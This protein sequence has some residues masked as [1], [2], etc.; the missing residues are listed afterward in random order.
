MEVLIGAN[1][2]IS[3]PPLVLMLMQLFPPHSLTHM[4]TRMH[5]CVYKTCHAQREAAMDCV[6]E[7]DTSLLPPV[8]PK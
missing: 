1:Y 3:T 8:L 2:S 6:V 5:M 7:K 4:Y